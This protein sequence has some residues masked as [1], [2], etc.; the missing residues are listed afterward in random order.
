MPLD[1]LKI[2]IENATRPIHIFGEIT[3]VELNKKWRQL[4]KLVH[5]DSYIN[6]EYLELAEHLFIKLH[7]MYEQAKKEFNTGIYNVFDTLKLY[8]QMNYLFEISLGSNN[9]KFYEHYCEGEVAN[10]Y[11]GTNGKEIIYL[12]VAIENADNDLIDKEYEALKKLNHQ[13]I[14]VVETNLK[15]NNLSAFIMKEVVGLTVEELMEYFPNG[16]PPEH[17]MWILERLLGV[18]GYLHSNYI[19][20][21]NIKPEHIIINLEKH[22]ATIL[23]FSMSILEA[24]KDDSKY[25]I[26][27]DNYSSPEIDINARVLPNADIYS[28]GKIAIQLLGGDI[29]S[30]G[31]PIHVNKNIRDFIRTLVDSNP[32]TRNNDAWELWDELIKLRN[33]EYGTVRFKE[34]DLRRRK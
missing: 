3:E 29:K 12:K 5:P 14:P 23:G 18:L 32:R 20:H 21:G 33:T 17:V 15:I 9:Y 30:N 28:V 8:S 22:N 13:S 34:I 24:N 31:M 1:D 2:L 16:V 10:I 11:K 25:M 7:T 27:N 4:S 19:V 26:K 6:T